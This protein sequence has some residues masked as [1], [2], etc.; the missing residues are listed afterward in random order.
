MQKENL[1]VNVGDLHLR[2][3]TLL[4]A[5]LM[6]L[7][8]ASLKRVWNSGAGGVITK[9]MSKEAREGYLGPRVVETPCGLINSMGLPNPGIESML[10]EIKIAKDS[11]ALVVGSI[12]GNEVKEFAELTEKIDKVGAAAI[13][14]NLSCPHAEDL[15]TIGQNPKLTKKVIEACSGSEIPIWVKLPGNTHIS[16]LVGVTKSAEK[17]GA[18]A[19]VLT[20]TLPA[21]SI[22]VTSERPILGHG[23][24]GLSGPAI[25]PI[26]LRLV[27]EVYE[28]IDIPIVGAGGIE[29]GKDMI[30]YILAGA[31]AVEI[32]TGMMERNLD[33]FKKVC[34]EASTFLDGR[35]VDDL[36][37]SAHKN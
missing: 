10:E 6:G 22:D 24:G 25:K 31:S 36:V 17:A 32:G 9:S 20:N 11:G 35:E 37:G 2:N 5:G 29:S 28:K 4:A 21:M 30:E 26:G 19:I 13:E 16:N 15:S 14:L 7:T 18:D 34:E 23:V 1:H 27:Y 33:I 3:P 8:G 12:F